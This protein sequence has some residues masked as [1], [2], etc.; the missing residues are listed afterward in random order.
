MTI[1]REEIFGPVLAIIGYD[2]VDQAIEIANDTD[3]GLG[4]YVVGATSRRAPQVAARMR[5]GARSRS[6]AACD[7]NAPFGGYKQQRQRA[8]VGRLRLPGVPGDQ[9]HPRLRGLINGQRRARKG[10]PALPANLGA[11]MTWC[12]RRPDRFRSSRSWALQ[13]ATRQRSMR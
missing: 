7:F 5:A 8:R 9:G 1:A 10:V 3:Y 2:G 13:F 11:A 4:G 12:H 6:T